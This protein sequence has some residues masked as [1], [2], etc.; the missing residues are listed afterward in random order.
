LAQTAP[1]ELSLSGAIF[2][3]LERSFGVEAA[4]RDSAAASLSYSAARALRFPDLS[5]TALSTYKDEV[6]RLDINMPPIVLEREIGS[7]ETYQADV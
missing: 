6:A 7:K 2:R 1:I 5:L 4:R 3:S